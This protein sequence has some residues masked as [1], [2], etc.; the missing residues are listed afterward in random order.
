MNEYGAYLAFAEEHG[1]T[2]RQRLTDTLRRQRLWQEMNPIR[3]VWYRK[4]I[5]VHR[6]W[7]FR[8]AVSVLVFMLGMA[9]YP[10]PSQNHSQ[11]RSSET[12]TS[13][14]V[15]AIR[16]QYDANCRYVEDNAKKFGLAWYAA[17]KCV[18]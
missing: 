12:E 4:P 2:E 8:L 14:A 9:L 13:F 10:S 6:Y 16:E 1:K 18:D 7:Y 5:P 15:Q 3:N 11:A 17:N